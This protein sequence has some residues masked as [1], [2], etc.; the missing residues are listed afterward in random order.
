VLLDTDGKELV[1]PPIG[2]EY[3]IEKYLAYLD[4]G[5]AEF[6]NRKK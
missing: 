3:N 5:L 2:V 4:K 6:A 1:S